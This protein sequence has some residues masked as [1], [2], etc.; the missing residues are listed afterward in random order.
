MQEPKATMGARLRGKVVGHFVAGLL[1]VVPAAASVLIFIWLFDAVDSILQPIISSIA[2]H[3]ITGV[4]FGVTILL[5][6]VVGVIASTILG[7]RIVRYAESLLGRVPIFRWVYTGIKHITDGFSMPQRSGFL[8]VVLVEFP[9][10]GMVG[11]GFVTSETLD[12]VS[13]R[14]LLSIFI[15]TAPNPTAGFLQI[16]SE[17]QVIRTQLTV[18]D[19]LKMVI[20]A[21][22]R[23]PPEVIEKLTADSA[24]AFQNSVPRR[25]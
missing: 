23:L 2:G 7:I 22:M 25:E 18:D 1:V 11:L 12:P 24:P 8:R 9:R 21:G 17:D 20:S 10:K 19:A 5:I 15:P 14:K 3:P 13:G 16:V 4:G 6:Y